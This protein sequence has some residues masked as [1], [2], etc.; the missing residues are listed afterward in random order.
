MEVHLC[1]CTFKC[2]EVRTFGCSLLN[3]LEYAI[4]ALAIVWDQ[5]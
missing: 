3:V 1:A 4:I 2:K 5:S